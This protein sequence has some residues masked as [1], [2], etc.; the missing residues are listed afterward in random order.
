MDMLDK[1][2]LKFWGIL[3]KNE[4]VYLM[5]GGF[6]VKMPGYIRATDDTDLWLKDDIKSRKG[7]RETFKELGYGDYASVETME[8]VPG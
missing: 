6:A 4:V 5:V 8:F 2:L 3:N 1:D 7:L